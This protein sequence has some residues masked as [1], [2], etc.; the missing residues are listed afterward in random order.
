VQKQKQTEAAADDSTPA[1]TWLPD[2]YALTDPL[3][4]NSDKSSREETTD[5][6]EAGD[7]SHRLSLMGMV[8]CGKVCEAGRGTWPDSVFNVFL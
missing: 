5:K 3:P 2:E 4:A 6:E 7:R 1:A 8:R